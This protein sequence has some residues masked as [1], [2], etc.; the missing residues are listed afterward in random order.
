[1]NRSLQWRKHVDD[2]RQ[3][4]PYQQRRGMPIWY[5]QYFACKETSGSPCFWLTGD[6]SP[7]V[8][9]IA[10]STELSISHHSHCL[11]CK[12]RI[13]PTCLL[14]LSR[15]SCLGFEK[16]PSPSS[17]WPYQI[18]GAA[19][20]TTVPSLL[21]LWHPH[22]IGPPTKLC[23]SKES[24]E[25]GRERCCMWHHTVATCM[26]VQASTQSQIYITRVFFPKK[27]C[28]FNTWRKHPST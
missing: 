1:M 7:Q 25:R 16:R 14:F 3:Q 4:E 12:H 23:R 18:W 22:R 21:F 28:S 15:F 9:R 17:A 27:N 6:E 8:Q 2:V 5:G 20:P 24:T 26:V 10:S 19:I 11:I 13:C